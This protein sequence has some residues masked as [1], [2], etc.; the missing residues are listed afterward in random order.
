MCVAGSVVT[1][2]GSGEWIMSPQMPRLTEVWEIYIRTV[3]SQDQ[4]ATN[5]EV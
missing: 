5:V 3:K 2:G 4:S 1:G